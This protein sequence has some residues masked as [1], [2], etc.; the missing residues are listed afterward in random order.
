MSRQGQGPVSFVG[1]GRKVT[2]VFVSSTLFVTCISLPISFAGLLLFPD[3]TGQEVP[4]FL[5]LAVP[6]LVGAVR[7]ARMS[8]TFSPGVCEIRNQVRTYR[9]PIDELAS[10][11]PVRW[12]G[13]FDALAFTPRWGTGKRVRAFAVGSNDLPDILTAVASAGGGA[14][15]SNGGSD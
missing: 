4:I 10:V 7:G 13:R 14:A 6:A 5:V 11:E 3:A 15:L 1:A 8:V 12:R 9:M 2:L